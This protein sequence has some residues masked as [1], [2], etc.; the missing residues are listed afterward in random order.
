MFLTRRMHVKRS[1]SFAPFLSGSH[2]LT[3]LSNFCCWTDV[4]PTTFFQ[5][6]WDSVITTTTTTTRYAY[7]MF[8]FFWENWKRRGLWRNLF[9]I[10]TRL[11]SPERQTILWRVSRTFAE[12]LLGFF[13]FFLFFFFW[14]SKRSI[15]LWITMECKSPSIRN[16]TL[17]QKK[18]NEKNVLS[19][20][21]DM[22]R[23]A[24]QF[25]RH[26]P[27]HCW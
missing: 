12:L 26:Y 11:S 13:F 4:A 25:E 17:K 3:R 24:Q 1:F 5:T 7:R 9:R 23:L 20:D 15:H 10:W 6:D 14:Y 2:K 22:H 16:G 19:A 21:F 8:F 18:N 27:K